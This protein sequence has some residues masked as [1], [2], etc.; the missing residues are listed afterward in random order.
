[1]ESDLL[2]KKIYSDYL[3]RNI[4]KIPAINSLKTIIETHK[5]DDLRVEAL[6]LLGKII[7]KN[8][9]IYKFLKNLAISDA[10]FRLRS[11]AS[12]ILIRYFLKK[13]ND[14]LK[15]IIE[16]D[17]SVLILFSIRS[18]LKAVNG[19][20]Y[21]EFK[22]IL[23]N[24]Y[25]KIYDLVLNEA[26]FFLDLEFSLCESNAEDK[27]NVIGGFN[28][29]D[30]VNSFEDY[31]CNYML[32]ENCYNSDHY[33]DG[34]CFSKIF[35]HVIMLNLSKWKL[36]A[37]PKSIEQL[38]RLRSLNLSENNLDCLP[39]SIGKLSKL[40]FLNLSENNLTS[41]PKSIENL[42][43]LKYLNISKNNFKEIPKSIIKF[44][45]LKGI[46]VLGNNL[47]EIPEFLVRKFAKKY[48]KEGVDKYD[49]EVIGELEILSGAYFMPPSHLEMGLDLE[50]L[51]FVFHDD[52]WQEGWYYQI[53]KS[54]HVIELLI[55]A[56]EIGF[57]P[58]CICR[59]RFLKKLWL[60]DC[61]IKRIPESISRLRAL[62]ELDLENNSIKEIPKYLIGLK[63]LNVLHLRNNKIELIHSSLG[64]L[65][66]LVELD[67]VNNN[68]KKIPKN[69]KRLKSLKVLLLENNKIELIP[70][71]LGSLENLVRLNLSYNKIK[72]IPKSISN[73]KK[74]KFLYLYDNRI[75]KI[76]ETIGNLKMLEDLIVR[77]N[78]IKKIPNSITELGRLKR[79]TLDKN[80]IIDPNV[81]KNLKLKGVSI[82][83]Y[84]ER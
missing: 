81:V 83:Y 12:K 84:E 71:S 41:L 80:N 34:C 36:S 26:K 77:S 25:A 49:A 2:I 65:E 28:Y 1:M 11:E 60:L 6:K 10:N 69:L 20:F 72:N 15:W 37:I 38:S 51:N 50:D 27:D 75:K 9:E 47:N 59:L 35:K 29:D 64:S 5:N 53:N 62:R 42:N 16:N 58:E 46:C 3:K 56:T 32:Y 45:K 33:L 82:H 4:D 21:E 74:L 57:F 39:H 78:E 76:P 18:T 40:K 52:G 31:Y 30:D 66:N 54:G 14:V 43:R 24:R 44:K 55:S 8:D 61:G 48:V 67:L 7:V 73:L 22:R 68:I 23:L 63:T 19:L 13:G 79:L 70:N 17:N